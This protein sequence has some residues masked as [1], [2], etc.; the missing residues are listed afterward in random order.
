MSL[1]PI[2]LE[3]RYNIDGDSIWDNDAEFQCERQEEDD[4][5]VS[6]FFP[7]D[8]KSG[9]K[10]TARAMPIYFSNPPESLYYTWYLK[11]KDC[12]AARCD[13]NGDGAYNS[14][15]W[16][17]EAASILVQNGYDNADPGTSYAVD[18]D[19]DGCKAR[20]GGDNKEG[21]TDYCAVYELRS[22]MYE[23]ANPG[24]SVLFSVRRGHSDLFGRRN[25]IRSRDEYS[26]PFWWRWCGCFRDSG[27]QLGG[28][29]I[30]PFLRRLDCNSGGCTPVGAPVCNNGSVL[31]CTSGSPLRRQSRY[32]R[33]VVILTSCSAVTSGSVTNPA[34][35]Y[36]RIRVAAWYPEMVCSAREKRNSG[37]R[38]RDPSTANNG[39]KMR[40]R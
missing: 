2:S 10:I 19:G 38:I 24:S 18:D 31:S 30:T 23:L 13:Y 34:S 40:L 9:G 12:N 21:R 25:E 6:I 26:Q 1:G 32:Q 27:R 7:S 3:Q 5:E 37:K 11:R 4:S 17:I 28:G 39:Q 14:K 22:G 35:M 8:P 33:P 36:L 16:R 15:D 20:F 29:T